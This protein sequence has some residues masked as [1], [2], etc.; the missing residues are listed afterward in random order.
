MLLAG[1]ACFA[2]LMDFRFPYYLDLVPLNAD[3]VFYIG[4]VIANTSNKLQSINLKGAKLQTFSGR[5]GSA[6]MNLRS[7]LF[8]FIG[9]A[10]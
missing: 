9:P 7:R 1:R 10:L 6:L 2:L 3:V 8:C 5:S 4:C